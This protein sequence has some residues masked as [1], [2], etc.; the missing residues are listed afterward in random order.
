[1]KLKTKLMGIVLI[2]VLFIMTCSTVVVYL[3][4]GRQYRAAAQDS[5]VNTA[6][7]IKDDLS[8]QMAKMAR[9]SDDLVRSTKM[10]EQIKFINDFF[11]G[12]Q[13]SITKGAYHRT[14]AS[15]VQAVSAGGLWQMVVYDGK[16]AILVYAEAGEENQVQ[17]GF[18]YKD[19]DERYAL[20]VVPKGAAIDTIEFQPGP[21]MPLDSISLRLQ[22]NLPQAPRSFFNFVADAVCMENQIPI[23]GN[24]YNKTTE[25]IESKV[26]GVLVSRILF[27]SAFAE[28]IAGLTKLAVNLFRSDG[29]LL[30]GTLAVYTKHAL[31][32][33]EGAKA[34]DLW[35]NQTL[36]FNEFNADGKGYFQASLPLFNEAQLIAWFSIAASKSSVA[37][38]TRRM[39]VMQSLV[40]LICLG[41]AMPFVYILARSFGRMV[42]SV[43]EGLRDIAEG[44]GDLTRRLE[45]TTQDELGDLAHWFNTFIENLQG[46]VRNIAGNAERLSSSSSDLTGLSKGMISSAE[47]VSSE[48]ETTAAHAGAVNN[49]ISSIAAAME[50]SSVNLTTVA[51]ATEEMTA[52][53]N[54]IARNTGQAAE[55]TAEA[56]HQARNATNLVEALGKAALD[57]SKVTETITEIS[58]QTNLLALN[59]TIEAARAGDA[60]KGFA[61]VA[62]EIKELARQTA[63]ATGEI[64]AKINGIQ[65][66]TN[67][68]VSEIEK[69]TGIINRVNDVVGTIATAVEEQSNN[70]TEIAGNVSQ[71]SSGIQEVNAKVAESTASVDQVAGNLSRMNQVSAEMSNQSRQVDEN[72]SAVSSLADELKELVERF[73]L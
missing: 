11:D 58:E 60:G 38:N 22:G 30:A 34:A 44:E 42:N 25:Q 50:E 47:A 36:M 7:I 63:T 31:E 32:G 71:A 27:T 43:V 52:T 48:S 14:V 41:V 4:L 64:K 19:P 51:S 61:V 70:A 45:I 16:G 46:I 29:Q 10:G 59:A 40:F 26:V 5:F 17:T 62:N 23:M 57:I 65:N 56:V 37:A 2:V 18:R 6:D 67:G 66:T 24:V 54:D 12:D 55:I 53:I 1:M 49:N 21:R 28:R 8:R 33:R 73:K 13:F 20:G 15:L 3:L 9:D 68:T 35:K 69:I 39:V 72:T